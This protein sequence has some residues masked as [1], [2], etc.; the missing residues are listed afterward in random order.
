[1]MLRASSSISALKVNLSFRATARAAAGLAENHEDAVAGA[2]LVAAREQD[3]EAEEH[4][5]DRGRSIVGGS[6]AR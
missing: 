4:Q 3:H 6:G 2:A 5:G 1:M